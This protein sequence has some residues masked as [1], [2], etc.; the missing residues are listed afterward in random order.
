MCSDSSNCQNSPIPKYVTIGSNMI[1][2]KAR[3]MI[4]DILRCG[5]LPGHGAYRKLIVTWFLYVSFVSLH[6]CATIFAY[7]CQCICIFAYLCHCKWPIQSNTVMSVGGWVSCCYPHIKISKQI[8]VHHHCCQCLFW[9]HLCYITKAE[10]FGEERWWQ[11]T[12][13]QIVIF[14]INLVQVASSLL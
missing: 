9:K 3:L 4:L 1:L 10:V 11:K 2:A 7:L 12:K 5:Y 13:T 6:I 8:N 14:I